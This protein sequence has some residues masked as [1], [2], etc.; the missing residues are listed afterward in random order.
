MIIECDD[1]FNMRSWNIPEFN[2]LHLFVSTISLTIH[3]DYTSYLRC[4]LFPH[5]YAA[6]ILTVH[7]FPKKKYAALITTKHSQRTGGDGHGY[8]H[9]NQASSQ[10]GWD[11]CRLIKNSRSATESNRD[12]RHCE[13]IFINTHEKMSLIRDIPRLNG[14]VMHCVNRP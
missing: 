9:E 7:P 13:N 8:Q 3:R 4:H 12:V 14:N 10:T 11:T 2:Q 5:I 6:I 1:N